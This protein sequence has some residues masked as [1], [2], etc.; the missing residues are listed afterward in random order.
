M[1]KFLSDK[2]LAYIESLADSLN[3]KVDVL[4]TTL[5]KALGT[6]P[7]KYTKK[8]IQTAAG[9]VPMPTTAASSGTSPGAG[10]FYEPSEAVRNNPAYPKVLSKEQ[11]VG[12]E[13]FAGPGPEKAAISG[14]LPKGVHAPKKPTLG[15]VNRILRDDSARRK[16]I[17]EVHKKIDDMVAG[18]Q[19]PA[20]F[21][22]AA[23]QK[24]LSF[25]KD[26]SPEDLLEMGAAYRDPDAPSALGRLA[27]GAKNYVMGSP[28]QR[29]GASKLAAAGI[30]SKA[31]PTVAGRLGRIAG[32][33]LLGLGVSAA[34]GLYERSQQKADRDAVMSNFVPEELLKRQLDNEMAMSA[35]RLQMERLDPDMQNKLV[36]AMYGGSRPQNVPPVEVELG[37]VADTGSKT[38]SMSELEALLQQLAMREQSQ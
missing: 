20:K 28:A 8:A 6:D 4:L 21:A 9:K 30:P 32:G 10:A 33:G 2:Q 12:L 7:S 23:K 18:G 29:S 22:D 27:K 31:I 24:G 38:N 16:L 35:R 37:D 19:I 15:D 14:K 3:V 5:K 17:Q 11:R 34:M 13:A 26:A 1:A 36:D 25:I